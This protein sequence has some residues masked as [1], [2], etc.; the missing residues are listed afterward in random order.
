M[1]NHYKEQRFLQYLHKYVEFFTEF[2]Y[3]FE[4]GKLL[5]YDTFIRLKHVLIYLEFQ[6]PFS[7]LCSELFRE[8]VTTNP[9][10]EMLS[11]NGEIKTECLERVKDMKHEDDLVS[12]TENNNGENAFYLNKIYNL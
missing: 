3:K 2:F 6:L 12:V 9:I 5:I 8:G 10:K 7:V 4:K 11:V 1:N